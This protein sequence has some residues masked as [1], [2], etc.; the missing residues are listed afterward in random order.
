[1]FGNLSQNFTHVQSKFMRF[2]QPAYDDEILDRFLENSANLDFGV[3]QTNGERI[4]HVVLPPWAKNDPLLFIV[5]H[6]RVIVILALLSDS[7][8]GCPGAGE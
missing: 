1:M 4:H 7:T 3:Q 6:R 5:L 2:V 8:D